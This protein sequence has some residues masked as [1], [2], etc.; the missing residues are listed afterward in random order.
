VTVTEQSLTTVTVT[1]MVPIIPAS[2]QNAP[3]APPSKPSS[4]SIV[5]GKPVVT[6]FLPPPKR[7]VAVRGRS[8]IV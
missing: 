1:Q 7:A 5:T 4:V 3:A 8:V 6:P 2:I